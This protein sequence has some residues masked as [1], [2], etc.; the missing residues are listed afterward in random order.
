MQAW[1]AGKLS[2]AVAI[3]TFEIYGWK[4]SSHLILSELFSSLPKV[5]H[6]IK[7][8][9]EPIDVFVAVAVAAATVVAYTPY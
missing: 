3:A 4:F 5:G 9:K 7:S 6:V 8:C 1:L 2:A